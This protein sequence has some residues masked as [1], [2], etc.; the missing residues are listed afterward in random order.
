MKLGVRCVVLLFLIGIVVV[1]LY[2]MVISDSVGLISNLVLLC[3]EVIVVF[4]LMVVMLICLICKV[5]IGEIFSV[6][7][8]KFGMS[9]CICVMGVV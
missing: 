5:E 8:F 7:M 3:N 1:V 4:M 6:S 2:V 9:V